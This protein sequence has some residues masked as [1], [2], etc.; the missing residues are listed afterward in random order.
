MQSTYHRF[1]CNK[2]YLHLS[3]K[4]FLSSDSL[5]GCLHHTSLHSLS[6]AQTLLLN[7]THILGLLVPSGPPLEFSLISFS[8]NPVINWGLLQS[9]VKFRIPIPFRMW[10]FGVQA[11][12]GLIKTKWDHKGGALIQYKW[13]PF[14]RRETPGLGKFTEIY[15]KGHRVE[16]MAIYKAKRSPG[17]III[18][19]TTSIHNCDK[20]SCY[21][22]RYPESGAL[23]CQ[24]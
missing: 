13:W 9:Q 3:W 5:C 12:K 21:A 15:M 18:I 10:L 7:C 16:K 1:Q 24:P 8:L 20:I 17:T 19:W 4:T 23:Y 11:F 22:L 6:A 2:Y 14:E